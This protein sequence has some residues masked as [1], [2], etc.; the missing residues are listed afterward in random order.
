MTQ[1]SKLL[2]TFLKKK[3]ISELKL[4]F[5]HLFVGGKLD[6]Q[7]LK[8]FLGEDHQFDEGNYGL[9]WYGKKQC[10]LDI[11]VESTQMMV[12]D[13][14]RSVLPGKTKNLFIEGDNLDALKLLQD[15][16]LG[17][18]K[19][20]YID[21]PYNSGK[22]FGYNNQFK[23]SSNEYLNFLNEEGI[24]RVDSFLMHQ[25]ESGEMHTKWLNMMFPRLILSKKLMAENGVIMISIDESEKSNTQL[26]CNEIFG[27]RNF[28]GCFIWINRS[29]S[30][31]SERMFATTHEYIL[32]YAKEAK[33]LKFKGEKK[34]LSGYSNP[35]QDKNGDWM[36]D[37]PTASSGNVNS[38]FPIV[39]P[40]T[41]EEYFPPNGRYWAFSKNRV[42]EWTA[43]GKLVFFKEHGKRFLLKKYKNELK[44][45]FKPISSVISD[46]PTSK[47]TREL[48]QLYPEGIPFKYPKP[49]DLLVKLFEQLTEHE[50]IIL[51]LFTGSASTAHAVF[52]LNDKDQS[53]RQFISIQTPELCSGES[54]AYQLGFQNIADLARDRIQRSGAIYPS[55]DNGF[56]FYQLVEKNF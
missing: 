14:E 25:I 6:V 36:P 52:K 44:S 48:K 24:G 51:D 11:A 13:K 26:L 23:L 4:L 41:N 47:G 45:N 7:Q 17:K 55:V 3:K 19:L 54:E 2:A 21:P 39:N 15:D 32:L 43:S 46:I 9:N 34:D 56:K 31:D 10:L 22:N 5:P 37:N 1:H 29:I 12:L 40:Y 30:N 28:M 49:T 42:E 27:E 16:Y 8:L 18:I 53:V 38:R 35:D 20:I 50:D 33:K